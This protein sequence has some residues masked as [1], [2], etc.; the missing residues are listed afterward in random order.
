MGGFACWLQIPRCTESGWFA[1]TPQICNR[2]CMGASCCTRCTFAAQFREGRDSRALHITVQCL[3]HI[4]AI[5]HQARQTAAPARPRARAA[6]RPASAPLLAYRCVG[7]A[8]AGRHAIAPIAGCSSRARCRRPQRRRQE[9]CLALVQLD[10]GAGVGYCTR[11][12][13]WGCRCRRHYCRRHCRPLPNL[14]LTSA[15]C[16]PL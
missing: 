5:T 15:P 10:S 3:P 16:L 2:R 7:C 14:C 11:R 12:A 9:S 1:Q 6:A 8:T 4:Q 13:A